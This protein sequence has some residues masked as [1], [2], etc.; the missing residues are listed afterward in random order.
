LLV[1]AA[2]SCAR[3]L[4]LWRA[5]ALY[6]LGAG[7]V[8]AGLCFSPACAGF[9]EGYL[10][11][12]KGEYGAAAADLRPIA[13]GADPV[14]C[15]FLGIMYL[16]GGSG[17]AADASE[18]RKW[19]EEA[20]AK[21]YAMAEYNLGLIHLY[22]RGVPVDYQA[23]RE[24]LQRAVDQGIPRAAWHLAR[25]YEKGLGVPVKL[26]EAKRLYRWATEQA[27]SIVAENN[28]RLYAGSESITLDYA[29]ARDWY[30]KA[31]ADGVAEAQYNLG[32]MY[33]SGR[34]I[35][36]DYV[37]ALLWLDRAAAQGD[38]VAAVKRD[39]VRGAMTPSELDRAAKLIAN[40]DK[41][42]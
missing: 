28:G 1:T 38:S 31:A 12:Q 22:G 33:A 29:Q 25:I 36:Q 32:V 4:R 16:Y 41:V 11:Y 17:L 7:A 26:D 15:Y 37:Q 27:R 39:E 23:A 8:L 18:A 13:E 30:R 40:R 24:F 20:N 14:A 2:S 9:A 42:N 19:L 21:G 5:A 6:R 3:A 34:G 10:A 35:Q